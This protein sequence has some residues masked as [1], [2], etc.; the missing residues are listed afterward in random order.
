[1]NGAFLQIIF[2]YIYKTTFFKRAFQDASI[3]DSEY[4]ISILDCLK[5]IKKASE[6]GFF[7][8]KDFNFDEYDRLDKI[9]GGDLNWIVPGAI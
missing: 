4:T 6:L 7:D 3:G 9:A 5:A 1:M 2:I 8:F